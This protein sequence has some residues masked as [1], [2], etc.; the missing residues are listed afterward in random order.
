M[1]KTKSQGCVLYFVSLIT[2][3]RRT[4]AFYSL[5]REL[6]LEFGYP[7]WCV[8]VIGVFQ[9]AV[10]VGNYHGEGVRVCVC[11]CVC[12]CVC[13][14][15]RVCVREFACMCVCMHVIPS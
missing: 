8:P 5:G 14:C 6:M 12:T 11:V 2:L 13:V 15:V 4:H 1:A 3:V 9:A 7:K 10:A